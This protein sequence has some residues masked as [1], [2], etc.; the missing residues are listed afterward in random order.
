MERLFQ[1]TILGSGTGV[2]LINRHAPGLVVQ[3]GAAQILFD[4]GSGTAHQLARAGFKYYEFDHLFYSHY[5]HPD[6]INDLSEFI[7][8]NAYFDPPPDSGGE[9]IF[10]PFLLVHHGICLGK[11]FINRARSIGIKPSG[12]DTEREPM[13]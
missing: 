7:F 13:G 8:A 11:Q 12:T 1:L 3:A 10:F 9:S 5:A 4:S 6:H 2:P